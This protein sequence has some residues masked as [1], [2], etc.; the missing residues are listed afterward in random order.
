MNGPGFWDDLWRT[1]PDS[2]EVPDQILAARGWSVPGVD[3]SPPAVALGRRETTRRR[4][5][6]AF[7]VG[8]LPG[9][10]S[11]RRFDLV[12]STLGTSR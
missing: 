12:V 3:V 5:D 7:E 1:D 2:V 4:F 6:A 11:D 8:E 9:W 10:T